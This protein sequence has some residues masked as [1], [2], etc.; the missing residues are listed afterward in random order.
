[1]RVSSTLRSAGLPVVVGAVV[2]T[3][4]AISY[5]PALADGDAN[6]NPVGSKIGSSWVSHGLSELA[7]YD[8]GTGIDWEQTPEIASEDSRQGCDSIGLGCSRSG[9]SYDPGRPKKPH[10]ELPGDISRDDCP[11]YRY[12]IPDCQRAGNPHCVASWAQLSITTKYSAGFVGGGAALGG[13]SRYCSEGVWGLDYHGLLPYRR[14]WMRWTSGRE[15]G[16]EGAY[17]TDGHTGPF[18]KH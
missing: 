15:Q 2:F 12:T 8:D 17:K 5:S 11:P 16:G 9:L 10:R 4:T 3:L 14:V 18:A 7:Y 13:R 6:A 1:M